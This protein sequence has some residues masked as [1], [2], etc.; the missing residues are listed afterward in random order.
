MMKTEVMI[1]WGSGLHAMR[2]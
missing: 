1:L 2:T